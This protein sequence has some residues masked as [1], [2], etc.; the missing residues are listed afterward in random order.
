M[1]IRV[2]LIRTLIVDDFPAIRQYLRAILQEEE[3]IEVVG[4]AANGA[5][6]VDRALELEPDVVVMDYHMPAM[7]GTEATRRLKELRPQINVVFLALDPAQAEEAMASGASA[8]CLK[9]S[10]P[11]ELVSAIRA[12]CE[13]VRPIP[14]ARPIRIHPQWWQVLLHL[15]EQGHLSFSQVGRLVEAAGEGRTLAATLVEEGYVADDE[16]VETLSQLLNLP[17]VHLARYPKIGAP[18]RPREKRL[19]IEEVADPVDAAAGRLIG[20]EMADYHCALPICR[21]NG[22]LTVAMADPLD[23]VAQGEIAAATGLR[24]EPVVS[25]AAEIRQAVDRLF[26]RV[27]APALPLPPLAPPPRAV[28]A[29]WPRRLPVTPAEAVVLVTVLALMAAVVNLL[30]PGLSLTYAAPLVGLTCGLFFF[31][32]AVKYYITTVWVLATAV[33]RAG[34]DFKNGPNDKNG[35]SEWEASGYRTLNGG[36]IDSN[37]QIVNHADLQDRVEGNPNPRNGH[38]EKPSPSEQPF[39]AVHLATYNETRVIDRLLTACTSFDYDNYEV[40]VV[41]DSTDDTV[42]ILEKWKRHPRVKVI[43]RPIRTGFKGAALQVALRHSNPRARY[44]MI[45]DADFVPAPD[46]ILRFLDHFQGNGNHRHSNMLGRLA[47][48]MKNGNGRDDDRVAAVQ[49]Y[50]WHIL[51]ASENW[52]TRGVRVEYSGSYILERSGQELA[53]GMKMIAGTVYMIRADVLRQLGWSTSITE[54]WDLTCRLYQAGYKVVYTPYVQAP[55]ECVSTFRSLVRQRMRWAE[56]HNYNVKKYFWQVIRSPYMSVT[57][58][59]EFLYYAPYYLQAVLFVIGT[60]AWLVSE[61]I[62]H[63]HIPGWIALFGWALLFS[64]MLALPLMNFSGLLVEGSLRRDV[65]GILS[66][67][68]LSNMMVPFQAWASLKGLLAKDEGGWFRT[69]KTGRITEA[70]IIFRLIRRFRWLLPARRR[71]VPPR[72][73]KPRPPRGRSPRWLPPLLLA[74]IVGGIVLISVLAMGVPTTYAAPDTLYTHDPVVSGLPG[75]QLGPSLPT[76]HGRLKV[77]AANPDHYWYSEAYPAGN[78]PGNIAAGQYDFT[79]YYEKVPGDARSL[80]YYVEVGY[81]DPDGSNYTMLLRSPNQTV[82][83][84]SSIRTALTFNVG[85]TASVITFD[86]ASPKRLRLHI[87]GVSGDGS[88]LFFYDHKSYPTNLSIP[89][90]PTITVPERL[91]LWLMLAPVIPLAVFGVRRKMRRNRAE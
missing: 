36:F 11:E 84:N 17:R 76:E 13:G 16:L 8:Y 68:A 43:H 61:L 79:I 58:K 26:G 77:D 52:I 3:G 62:L 67:V 10:P 14:V 4:E 66:F 75:R 45:F 87:H 88:M 80:T 60:T 53:G 49:G 71:Q 24:V 73:R 72:E 18:I 86:A 34:Q 51:N 69:P 32:Y 91:W 27:Q 48:R 42:H 7:S 15:I 81:C 83:G 47:D 64:N 37:G 74:L 2:K 85:S 25:T 9:E 65:R 21:V 30:R 55:G 82:D 50:Q 78:D 23:S 90:T 57:E 12:A 20:E 63:Q 41:D 56:G 54:D 29:W 1:G 35:G 70:V 33:V 46:T 38:L 39:V 6:A 22:T 5:Q 59:L 40:V 28:P 19:C 44:M 31:A 89:T